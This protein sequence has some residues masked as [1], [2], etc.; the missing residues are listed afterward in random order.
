MPRT[1]WAPA[2]TDDNPQQSFT[3]FGRQVDMRELRNYKCTEDKPTPCIIGGQYNWNYNYH[4]NPFWEQY[5]NENFDE[6]DR[7]L[8][9]RRPDLPGQRLDHRHWT[10]RPRLVPG[11]SQ[12]G[13]GGLQ[14]GE[15][16]WGVW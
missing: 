6:K 14:S 9:E 3:W 16:R 7:L 2:T 15:P 4:N 10:D 1:A 13:H 11:P 5:V 8:G 12:E